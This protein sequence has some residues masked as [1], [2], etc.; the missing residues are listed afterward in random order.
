MWIDE[1]SKRILDRNDE[2]HPSRVELD[3]LIVF[4]LVIVAAIVTLIDVLFQ[5]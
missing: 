1:S 2:T 3:A 4:T 5:T